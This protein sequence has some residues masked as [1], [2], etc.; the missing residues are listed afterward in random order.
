MAAAS[1][2]KGSTKFTFSQDI[3]EPMTE[4]EGSATSTVTTMHQVSKGH[5]EPLADCWNSAQ[6]QLWR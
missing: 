2:D 4:E 5:M 6:H 3:A 1:T